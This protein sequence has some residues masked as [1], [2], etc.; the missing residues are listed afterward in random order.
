MVLAALRKT[1]NDKA[2]TPDD[3]FSFTFNRRQSCLVC[4]YYDKRQFWEWSKSYGYYIPAKDRYL[5]V[6]LF[7]EIHLSEATLDLVA[8]ELDHLRW[9]WI[10][11]R[12]IVPSPANE[13]RLT[14]LGDELTRK[15]WRAWGRH[16]RRKTVCIP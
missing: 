16:Y 14:R 8:H 3:S 12:G 10:F 11:S 15:F 13:E 5:R 2:M 6:G 9:D 7:G 1:G 4:L